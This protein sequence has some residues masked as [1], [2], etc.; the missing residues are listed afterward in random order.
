MGAV[1][2]E[3]IFVSCILTNRVLLL[4]WTNDNASTRIFSSPNVEYRL[5]LMDSTI[6][7]ID[8]DT[9]PYSWEPEFSTNTLSCTFE[10]TNQMMF[11]MLK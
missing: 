4:E 7:T 5:L 10:A 3:P 8:D 1:K 11:Y 6:Y 2:A 9:P